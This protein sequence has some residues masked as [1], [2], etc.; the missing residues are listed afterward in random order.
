MTGPFVCNIEL[1]QTAD[2]GDAR[3]VGES[4]EHGAL[5]GTNAH[6]CLGYR[7]PDEAYQICQMEHAR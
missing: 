4:A 3:I 7:L 1:H 2:L 5:V 6:I